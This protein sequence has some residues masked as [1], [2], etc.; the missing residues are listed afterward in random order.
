VSTRHRPRSTRLL[1]V[2]L[3]SISLAVI[4]LD[5]RQ[6]Q[7]GPLAG[8]GRTARAAMAP[9]QEAVTTVTRPVGDFFSGLAHLPSMAKENQDLKD[10]LAAS[11]AQNEITA[12]AQQQYKDLLDLL[13]L[14]QSLDPNA[15]PAVVIANGISNFEWSVTIDKGSADGIEPNMPV[16]AGT[17]LSP[18]LV[19]IVVET[20]EHSADVQL[21][22]DRHWSA[23]A[24]LGTSREAGEVQGQGDADL[25]MSL[26]TPGTEVA[27]NEAVFTLAY[28]ASGRPGLYPT[29]LLIGQ[30]SRTV[31]ADNSIEEFVDVR[32]AV[33]FATLQFVLVLQTRARDG[34]A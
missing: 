34:A 8:F 2:V 29:G 27:G 25:R 10:Q 5:Y 6:G 14:Q 31:P 22:L 20:T 30:V 12:F 16:V 26:V 33:D 21:M 24:V 17:A 4:T 1:V 15:V 9:M 18:L 7:S 19:G 23:A 32:P 28:Q 3:V 11:E 13:E